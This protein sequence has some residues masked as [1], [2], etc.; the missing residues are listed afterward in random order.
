MGQT[1]P[2][3]ARVSHERQQPAHP[4]TVSRTNVQKYTADAVHFGF[5]QSEVA[6]HAASELAS[7]LSVVK[8]QRWWAQK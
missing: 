8:A 4:L 6:G 2:S 7:W 1:V 3:T 5:R